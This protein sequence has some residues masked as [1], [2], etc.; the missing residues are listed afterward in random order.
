[1]NGIGGRVR[2]RIGALLDWLGEQRDAFAALQSLVVS[3]GLV[4]GAVWTYRIFSATRQRDLAED[5][6][7]RST[8]RRKK[9]AFEWSDKARGGSN[10]S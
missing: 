10:Y 4:L 3:C 5:S 6:S 7:P 8:S 9:P 2:R 1:M